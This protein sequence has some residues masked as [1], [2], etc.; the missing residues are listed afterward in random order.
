MKSYKVVKNEPLE[1]QQEDIPSPSPEQV[2]IKQLHAASVT[3]T[4]I[5]MM[6]IL[7]LVTTFIYQQEQQ[8]V[9]LQWDMKFM[10]KW[11]KSVRV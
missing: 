11:L 8:I 9:Q 2:L 4:Y 5:F 6:A 3:Q 1:E 7:T 10:A